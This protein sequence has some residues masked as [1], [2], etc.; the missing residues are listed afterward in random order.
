MAQMSQSMPVDPEATRFHLLFLQKSAEAQLCRE[1]QKIGCLKEAE[2]EAAM[3]AKWV[4]ECLDYQEMGAELDRRWTHLFRKQEAE[5]VAA[6]GEAWAAKAA[7]LS[8]ELSK[9]ESNHGKEV[10]K[11]K[12][13]KEMEVEE[14]EEEKEKDAERKPELEGMEGVEKAVEDLTMEGV[15]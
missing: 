14:K 8:T 13:E 15:E 9:E 5:K 7:G 10:D 6:E 11:G 2:Y 3:R 4:A 1:S 12:E